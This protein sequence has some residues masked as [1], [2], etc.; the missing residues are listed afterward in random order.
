MARST[1]RRRE[2]PLSPIKHAALERAIWKIA[3]A[4]VGGDASDVEVRAVVGIAREI[5]KDLYTE[6]YQPTAGELAAAA[7][8]HY[9]YT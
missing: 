8:Q 2:A 9:F 3:R 1:S 4:W 6:F 5:E 7:L